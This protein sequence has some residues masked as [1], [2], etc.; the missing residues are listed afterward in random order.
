[1]DFGGSKNGFNFFPGFGKSLKNKL[2][3][4]KCIEA[5][6]SQSCFQ[7]FA[8]QISLKKL[9]IFLTNI[10]RGNLFMS[11]TV[12]AL[13][14]GKVHTFG[15]QSVEWSGVSESSFTKN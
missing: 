11:Q 7:S 3:L 13:C 8:F 9:D 5:N 15:G 6:C 2:S 4:G 12:I 1:M 10:C 14:L